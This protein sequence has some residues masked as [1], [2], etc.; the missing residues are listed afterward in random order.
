[1]TGQGEVREAAAT[2][3]APDRSRLAGAVWAAWP[4]LAW[5]APLAAAITILGADGRVIRELEGPDKKGLHRVNWDLRYPLS[6]KGEDG[7]EGWFG[8]PKG[9]FVLP[10]TYTV[11]LTAR[12]KDLTQPVQVRVD[13]RSVTTAVTRPAFAAGAKR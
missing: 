11:K 4:A 12:G 7:D 2:R 13:P 6:Y 1:M 3:P 10:G 9:T 8:P 5:C